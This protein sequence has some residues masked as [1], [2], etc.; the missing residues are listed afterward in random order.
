MVDLNQKTATPAAPVAAAAAA[1][2]T[3]HTAA[4][5]VVAAAPAAVPA[6]T[7]KNTP[8]EDGHA[9]GTFKTSTKPGFKTFESTVSDKIVVELSD[10]DAAKLQEMVKEV[11][12]VIDPSANLNNMIAASAEIGFGAALHAGKKLDEI[13]VDAMKAVAEK[14]KHKK[15]DH[16][17]VVAADMTRAATTPK[18]QAVATAQTAAAGTAPNADHNAASHA[19]VEHKEPHHNVVAVQPQAVHA[20]KAGEVNT[21]Q[22]HHETKAVVADQSNHKGPEQTNAQV[23][24]PVVNVHPTPTV[25]AK[26][27]V[28]P[29]VQGVGIASG[30]A[31]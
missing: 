22:V 23:C 26:H 25:E 10:A 16:D 7:P 8:G 13:N 24:A 21:K 31:F 5:T 1:S 30:V 18:V 15:D 27:I 17:Y 12:R 19:K 28:T 3:P 11:A 29:P 20:P 14:H 6:S 2:A 4:A 9:G